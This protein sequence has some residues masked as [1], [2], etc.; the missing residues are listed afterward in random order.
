[1]ACIAEATF[2]KP[3]WILVQAI[4]IQALLDQAILTET[5]F[6]FLEG[7]QGR[8]H[9]QEILQVEV[10]IDG[11]V[12]IT[13]DAANGKTSLETGFLPTCI[14]RPDIGSRILRR[15]ISHH[16]RQAIIQPPPKVIIQIDHAGAQG[17]K[18]EQPRLGRFVVRQGAVIVKMV[19]GEIG[20]H[21][22]INLSAVEPALIQ[23]V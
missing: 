21:G 18:V 9:R 16:I 15:R 23:P 14:Q 13:F 5:A 11:Q 8:R 19:V 1:M 4:L 2:S 6:S 22:D 12:K 20:Q 17:R 7:Q 10:A 3:F